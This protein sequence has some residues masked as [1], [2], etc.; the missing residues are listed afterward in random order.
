MKASDFLKQYE[1][2]QK[3]EEDGD[4][5]KEHSL[6]ENARERTKNPTHINAGTAY[7]WEDL[8]AYEQELKRLDEEGP[9][10][11]QKQQDQS[12]KKDA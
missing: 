7:D 8:E 6:E 4:Q 11:P 3:R 12:D 10:K 5:E 1:E 2:R 9:G